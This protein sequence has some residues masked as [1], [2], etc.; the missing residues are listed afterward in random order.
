MVTLINCPKCG[1]TFDL[2]QSDCPY[3]GWSTVND[4]SPLGTYE[5]V[6]RWVLIASN[7]VLV[8]VIPFLFLDLLAKGRNATIVFLAFAAVAAL[9]SN[10]IVLNRLAR[11]EKIAKNSQAQEK[12]SSS[13]RKP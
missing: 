12:P 2:E 10:L 6:M 5:R 7:V 9:I 8:V 1:N 13:N 11:R 3:C 4:D